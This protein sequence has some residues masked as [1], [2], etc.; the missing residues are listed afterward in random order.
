MAIQVTN[1]QVDLDTL[2][3]QLEEESAASE[4][5]RAQLQRSVADLQQLKSKY[6]KEVAAL[7]EQLDDTR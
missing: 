2:T 1:Y 7:S 3:S 4:A 5:A 6:D